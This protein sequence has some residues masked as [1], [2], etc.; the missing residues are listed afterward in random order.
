MTLDFSKPITTRDGQAVRILCTDGPGERP[1]VGI[2]GVS[3]KQ[4]GLDGG[5]VRGMP[6]HGSNLINPPVKRRGWVNLYRG[7]GGS[8]LSGFYVYETEAEARAHSDNTMTT[9][10]LPEWELRE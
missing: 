10:Q 3:A 9:V 8:I 4:W 2:V 1:I 7:H 5:Y 6:D